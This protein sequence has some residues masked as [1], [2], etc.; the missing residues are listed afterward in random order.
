MGL[1]DK[2]RQARLEAGLSQRQLCGQVITRNMLSLIESGKA[3]PS[4]AT[5]QYLSGQLGKTV[6]F[7]LEEAVA[8]SVNMDV[9]AKA[10]R[11]FACGNHSKVLLILEKYQRPDDLFDQEYA[12]LQA[13]STLALGQLLLKNADALHAVSQL[14]QMDRSS[15]YYREDMERQ[16]RQ[17]LT[18]GYQMLEQY[19][20]QQ[21]D[22]RNAY[23]YACKSRAIFS[24]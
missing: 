21:E 19:Y 9:M 17:L 7:F 22:Y 1:G 3:S 16:R 20:K 11:A 10:R 13:L 4:M 6:S 8:I 23:F 5:L 18:Q 12:Y 15:I 24:P 14:E 2:I